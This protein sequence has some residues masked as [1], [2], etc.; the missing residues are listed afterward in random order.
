MFYQV[1]IEKVFFKNPYSV[2]HAQLEKVRAFAYYCGK[3][4]VEKHCT[5]VC[6]CKKCAKIFKHNS[7]LLMLLISDFSGFLL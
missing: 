6:L 2:N 3:W 4:G 7:L 5:R 1:E